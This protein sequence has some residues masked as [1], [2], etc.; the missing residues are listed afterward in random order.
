M[1]HQAKKKYLFSYRYAGATWGGEVW[2]DDEEDARK[3]IRAM[4]QGA[5]DGEHMVS[6]PMPAWTERIWR[7]LGFTD[8]P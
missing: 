3:K 4:S 1:S 8:R 7:W 6:I 5:V 2:A